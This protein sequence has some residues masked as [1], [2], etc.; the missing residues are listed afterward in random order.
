MESKEILIKLARGTASEAEKDAFVKWANSLSDHEYNNLLLEYEAIIA[1]QPVDTPYDSILLQNIH[2][3]IH[4]EESGASGKVVSIHKTKIKWWMAA[5]VILVLFASGYFFLN[6]STSNKSFVAQ[7]NPASV[8]DIAP[9]G[10]KAVLT[11]ADGSTIVLDSAQN[12][13][14]A[15]QGNVK[16]IKLVN[17]KLAYQPSTFN[18]QSSTQYNTIS[19]PLGG[20]YQLDLADGSKVWLNSL[21]SIRFPTVFNGKERIVEITGEAYFEVAHNKEK[22][23]EVKHGDVTVQVLGTHFDVKTYSDAPSLKVTLLQGAVKVNKGNNEALLS[24]GWQADIRS[25][26]NININKDV[27]LEEVMAWKNGKFVFDRADI[28]TVMRRL[29]RWY[30]MDVAYQGNITAHFGGSVSMDVPISKVFEM[31]EMTGGV[32]FQIN[33]QNVTVLP[34]DLHKQ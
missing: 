6:R 21:S 33:G 28:Q 15:S 11:L 18:L 10:N 8:N 34:G 24:P 23:F 25:S 19:T 12:G 17:G 32:K 16:V 29:S 2:K 4:Q 9:G 14:L 20:K 30:K 26:G 13:I 5:A 7:N 22:P 27:N 31:L 1:K 3:Q